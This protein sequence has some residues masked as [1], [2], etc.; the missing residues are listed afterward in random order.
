MW[1]KNLYP[2]RAIPNSE[3]FCSEL[4]DEG[5]PEDENGFVFNIRL[6]SNDSDF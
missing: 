6:I 2:G 4:R 1:F 3:V 5:Y